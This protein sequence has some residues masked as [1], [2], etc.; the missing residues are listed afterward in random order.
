MQFESHPV[1]TDFIKLSFS[2]SMDPYFSPYEPVDYSGYYWYPPGQGPEHSLTLLSL[3]ATGGRSTMEEDMVRFFLCLV[4]LLGC[5][6]VIF[7]E[8]VL[9]GACQA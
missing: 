9:H 2:T 4:N 8:L 7:T 6:T 3:P 5:I 1:D